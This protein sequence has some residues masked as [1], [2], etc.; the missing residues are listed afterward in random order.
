M[1]ELES[2]IVELFSEVENKNV[3]APK[4]TE[5]PFGKEQLR[6]CTYMVPIKDL[7]NL[8]V[9]FPSP[10]LIEYY[11]SQVSEHNYPDFITNIIYFD[12]V[13][14]T[15]FYLIF[16]IHYASLQNGKYF[17]QFAKLH[18]HFFFLCTPSSVGENPN[19][20]SP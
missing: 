12:Q 17:L 20:P 13:G 4:W 8:H 2:I 5:Y 15:F 18:K 14:I 19:S 3:E 11:T 6:T 9:I 1:D 10:D 7:R 16:I